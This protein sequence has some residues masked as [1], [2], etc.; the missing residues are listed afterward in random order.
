MA[1]K[2]VN[3]SYKVD[4]S[5]L[6]KAKAT[7]TSLATETKKSEVAMTQLSQTTT[8]SGLV[9]SQTYE[10]QK[11]QMQQLRAQIDL[12]KQSDTA[13]L[14]KLTS[15]YNAVKAKVDEFNKSL[16]DSAK[17]GQ[18]NVNVFSSLQ[19][20]LVAIFSVAAVRQ[21]ISY[22]LEMSKL[23]G[24]V[25]GVSNA[26][27]KLPNSAILLNQ[28]QQATHG[29]VT[30]LQLMQKALQAQN[31]GI[32][33]EKLGSLLEF[34]STRAQQTGISVEYLV[35]SIVTGLGRDS[36]KILDNL[37]INIG[38]LKKRVAETGLTTKE[39]AIQMIGESLKT[40]D[41]YV[42][43]SATKVDQLSVSVQ[44]LKVAGSKAFES[45]GI[46][47]FFTIISEGARRA[48]IG[49]D[50]YKKGIAEQRAAQIAGS[51]K[52]EEDLDKEIAKRKESVDELN[53]EI[54]ALTKITP[55]GFL[56]KFTETTDEKQNKKDLENLKATR[57]AV[58]LVTDALE[59]LKTTF[60]EA[61]KPTIE[62][63][64]IIQAYK[65]QIEQLNQELEKATSTD[66]IGKINSQLAEL[67]QRLKGAQLIQ[68]I[69]P[70]DETKQ[71]AE[72]ERQILQ[73]AREGIAED[74]DKSYKKALVQLK[75]ADE[76][77]TNEKKLA[78]DLQNK[79]VLEAHAAELAAH[80]KLAAQK[81]S[82]RHNEEQM[83]FQALDQIL[84]A[85]LIHRQ[86]DTDSINAYYDAQIKAAGN[87]DAQKK[88]IEDKRSKALDQERVRQQEADKDAAI[89]KI[90]IDT[91]VAIARAFV[92]YPFPLAIGFA[93]AIAGAMLAQI[94]TVRSVKTATLKTR[95]FADGEVGIKGPGT[96]RSDSI[97]A[98]LSNGESVINAQATSQSRNLLEAI[99]ERRIDDRVLR[100]LATSGGSQ[101][102]AWDD[103]RIVQAI[104]RN[105]PDY[106]VQGHSLYK[107]ERVSDTFKRTIKVK[108]FGR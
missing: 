53:K 25:E 15:D 44:N 30:D 100:G 57:D 48:L 99:N 5:E 77:E 92:D 29:T 86:D 85:T 75:Q 24:Q 90:E 7:I 87:N 23:A 62:Q 4:D 51:A 89:T 83:A 6:L 98:M 68:T 28:L 42:V 47:D 61:E 12:T 19:S 34:A 96:A 39:V 94:A 43:N 106:F 97:P 22:T 78:L 80:Q 52:T 69:K 84:T 60:I 46:V 63:V 65:T 8:K 21:V 27:K 54:E 55:T 36:I 13:R 58:I 17:A 67:E 107:S 14:A 59:N 104:E 91:A 40:M 66:D 31:F 50:A 93:A 35:D 16:A 3:V 102:Q 73:D 108:V 64:G 76:D 71:D 11:L 81:A 95:A 82:I 41:K 33:L 101:A 32:P 20:T 37:Q 49:V 103:T 79:Q 10:G 2:I 26:F 18:N 70:S 56:S 74:A 1:K 9:I 88:A 38:E 72:N 105:K 45:G